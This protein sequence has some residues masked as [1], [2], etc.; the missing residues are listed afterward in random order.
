MRYAI[1]VF[2]LHHCKSGECDTTIVESVIKELD[3]LNY[4][5]ELA[6]KSTVTPGTTDSMVKK[7]PSL[8]LSFVPEF[9][10]ERCAIIDFVENHDIC[11]IGTNSIE[12]YELI[13]QSHGNLPQ[14]FI[15]TSPIEAELCIDTSIICIMRH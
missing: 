4:S 14:K 11:I 1:F 3:N 5:G 9:L 15:K 13:K 7:F 8:K 10:R 2:Q 12:S 6:I